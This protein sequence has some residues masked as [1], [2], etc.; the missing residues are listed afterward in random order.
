MITDPNIFSMPIFIKMFKMFRF[1][2]KQFMQ[3]NI[4]KSCGYGS[5]FSPFRFDTKITNDQQRIVANMC[6]KSYVQTLSHRADEMILQLACCWADCCCLYCHLFVWG[7]LVAYDVK[8]NAF[9]FPLQ[10]KNTLILKLRFT[11]THNVFQCGTSFNLS[12]PPA[13]RPSV[14]TRQTI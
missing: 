9:Q 12:K 1:D 10:I 4:V 11:A 8:R 5:C 6:V 3:E 13:M 14:Q 2:Y 7:S